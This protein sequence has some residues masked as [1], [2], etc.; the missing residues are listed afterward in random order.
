MEGGAPE[1]SVPDPAAGEDGGRSASSSP[2]P[3]S[4]G[5]PGT[6]QREDYLASLLPDADEPQSPTASAARATATA[7]GKWNLG[8]T[9]ALDEPSPSAALVQQRSITGAIDTI[10]YDGPVPPPPAPPVRAQGAS[11]VKVGSQ[12]SRSKAH[13]GS[14]GRAVLQSQWAA[15]T[16][17]PSTALVP[18]KSDPGAHGKRGK[19]GKGKAEPGGSGGGAAPDQ[20]GF[21]IYIRSIRGFGVPEGDPEDN[22][23]TDPYVHMALLETDARTLQSRPVATARTGVAAG[24]VSDPIWGHTDDLALEAPA[25]SP[26]ALALLNG[27]FPSLKVCIMDADD[28]DEDDL[29]GQAIV[30]LDAPIGHPEHVPLRGEGGFPDSYVSFAYEIKPHMPSPPAIILLKGLRIGEVEALGQPFLG[31]LRPLTHEGPTGVHL[32]LSL[33]EPFEHAASQPLSAYATTPPAV[34]SGTTAS[35]L[36][37]DDLYWPDLYDASVRLHLPQGG[38]RPA[39]VR[40]ELWDSEM[41][42]AG[43]LA[44]GEVT[45]GGSPGNV[46]L[47]GTRKLVLSAVP[48]LRDVAAAF[49][50]SIKTLGP[51]APPWAQAF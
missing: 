8:I 44:R 5:A 2:Q 50:Y 28:D 26:V 23:P 3:L 36:R 16:T 31:K 22:T 7:A 30:G 51:E 18:A 9:R 33:V 48:G 14:P 24:N 46:S 29:L 13:S 40:V 41:A 43:A 11:A 49:S 20:I 45:L 32:R 17:G 27:T 37:W 39:T 10:P 42:S 35:Q 38:P 19:H 12:R 47:S 4:P 15:P 34:P 6:K 1:A 21:H 25:G